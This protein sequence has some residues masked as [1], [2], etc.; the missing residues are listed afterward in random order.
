MCYATKY[1]LNVSD[2]NVYLWKL[3]HSEYWHFTVSSDKNNNL[4][5]VGG[6]NTKE[7]ASDKAIEIYLRYSEFSCS[8]YQWS[9]VD[10]IV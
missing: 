8:E 4:L 2:M 5:H 3:K 10:R 9:L 1:K 7:E 6:A